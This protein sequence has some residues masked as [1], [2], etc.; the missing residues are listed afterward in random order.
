MSEREMKTCPDCAEEVLA[1]ARKCRYCG[2]RFDGG[3]SGGLAGLFPWL[4]SRSDALTPRQMLAQWGVYVP[5]DEDVATVEFGRVSHRHGYLVVTD[6]RFLFVEHQSAQSYRTVLEH[7]LDSLTELDTD[8]A[9]SR[10]LRLRGQG[11]DF[12]I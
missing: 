12:V 7:S 8:A 9:H 11:Y 4:K 1:E 2:Y 10:S 5:A 6:R 3:R